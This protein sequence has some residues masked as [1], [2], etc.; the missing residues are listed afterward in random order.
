MS[1]VLSSGVTSC[2]VGMSKI[3]YLLSYSCV[4]CG[5]FPGGGDSEVDSVKFVVVVFC[6]WGY[7]I[8]D[9]Y[10]DGVRDEESGCIGEVAG[11]E[12]VVR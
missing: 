11:D 5:D 8:K 2:L 3:V 7:Q 9:W 10:I 12:V 6:G 4:W 1:F